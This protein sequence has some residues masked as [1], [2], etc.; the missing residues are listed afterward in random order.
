M[1]CI[2]L[3]WQEVEVKEV[4]LRDFFINAKQKFVQDTTYTQILLSYF[5]PRKEPAYLAPNRHSVAKNQLTVGWQ[6]TI[7]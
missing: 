7:V 1:Q 3:A 2:R 6:T 4:D 5:L